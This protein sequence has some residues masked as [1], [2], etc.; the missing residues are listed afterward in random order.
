M[1]GIADG[2]E[3]VADNGMAGRQPRRHP[4]FDHPAQSVGRSPMLRKPGERVR[5]GRA[6]LQDKIRH[7]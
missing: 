5:M 1:W 3:A 4:P 2:E 7:R 6:Q